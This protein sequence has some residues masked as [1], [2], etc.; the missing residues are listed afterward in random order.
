MLTAL[1]VATMANAAMAMY[2]HGGM[3]KAPRKGTKSA[4]I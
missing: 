4:V 1:L 3:V 2:S